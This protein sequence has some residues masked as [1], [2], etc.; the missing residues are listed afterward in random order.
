MGDLEWEQARQPE[1]C[2][3]HMET[4]VQQYVGSLDITVYDLHCM[5]IGQSFSRFDGDVQP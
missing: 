4:V 1:I 5:E 3:F 2:N